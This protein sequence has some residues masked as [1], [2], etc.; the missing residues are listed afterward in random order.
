MRKPILLVALVTAASLTSACGPEASACPAIAQATAV[1]VTVTAG[2]SPRVAT[3]HLRACQ[4]GTCT[5]GGVELRPG[6]STIDQGCNP[7]GSC[8]AT[9]SPDGT[10]VG[11]LMLAALTE[12]PMAVTASG[13]A[14]DGSA[15]P[16]RTLEFQPKAVY[17]FGEQCGKFLSAGV[18]LDDAG[19]HEQPASR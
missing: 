13:T 19:L 4:D 6:S 17:P 15:L 11:S 12:S 8:S 18:M 2:Y 1:A 5:E 10:K 3:L 9:A 14:A 16:V 7:E